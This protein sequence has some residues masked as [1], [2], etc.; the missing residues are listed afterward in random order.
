MSQ[1]ERDDVITS[2][3]RQHFPVLVA[4][5]V[6]CKCPHILSLSL[7]HPISELSCIVARGLDIPAIKTVISYDVPKNIDTHVHRIGRTGR[8]GEKGFA[9]TLVASKDV[10]FA[11]DLVRN[12]VSWRLWYVTSTD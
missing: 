10:A 5:D 9:Y 11:G 12:L 1:G 7:V 6:A 2:F 3:K 8:A 4:T